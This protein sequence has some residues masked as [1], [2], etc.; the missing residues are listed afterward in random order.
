MGAR[1]RYRLGL[2]VALLVPMAATPAAAAAPCADV[3]PA[4]FAAQLQRDFPAH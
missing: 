1:A 3:F 4:A 2:A